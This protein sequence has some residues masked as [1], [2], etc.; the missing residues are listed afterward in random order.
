M[1]NMFDFSEIVQNF[2]LENGYPE[3]SFDEIS[4][5]KR[6]V[7]PRE[8]LLVVAKTL[9]D[10]FY[11]DELIDTVSI[12]RFTEQNRFELI[13][14]IWS[15]KHKTRLFIRVKLDSKKPEIDSLTS[16]WQTANWQER[17]AYDMM[18]IIFIN[19]PD[20]RRIYMNDGY[21][22]FPLRKDYPLMGLPGAV[23]LPNK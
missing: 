10:K 11:F 17:E 15:N 7:I 9:R 12:D 16:I 14:N 8:Q 19:H 3:V 21:E 1:I 5:Y 13:Y 20:L 2:S 4:F 6:M 22:Y 18:G 23:E